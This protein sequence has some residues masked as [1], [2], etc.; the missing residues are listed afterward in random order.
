MTASHQYCRAVVNQCASRQLWDGISRNHLLGWVIHNALS[1][2]LYRVKKSVFFICD[3]VFLN[4][5]FDYFVFYSEFFDFSSFDFRFEFFNFQ[6]VCVIDFGGNGCSRQ[7]WRINRYFL[8]IKCEEENPNPRCARS[9]IISRTSATGDVILNSWSV[10]NHRLRSEV[11]PFPER[12]Q[13]CLKSHHEPT[14]LNTKQGEGWKTNQN[15]NICFHSIRYLR[16]FKKFIGSN[17]FKL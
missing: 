7:G 2:S 8:R 9:A 10:G 1:S 12:R 3:H 5:S 4:W 15:W 16:R 13:S 17:I 14:I 6:I 11:T